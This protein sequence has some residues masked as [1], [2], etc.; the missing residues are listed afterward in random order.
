MGNKQS[1][2]ETSKKGLS[3]VSGNDQ[4]ATHRLQNPSNVTAQVVM[5]LLSDTNRG[6][7]VTAMSITPRQDDDPIELAIPMSPVLR[8]K[9]SSRKSRI[10]EYRSA[11]R[12]NS[13]RQKDY[14]S[15]LE[16]A[17]KSVRKQENE[18][19]SIEEET[20]REDD[21]VQ[22]QK[23]HEAVANANKPSNFQTFYGS[24]MCGFHYLD[25]GL[26]RPFRFTLENV[27]SSALTQ[28]LQVHF[29]PANVYF[30][31]IFN[32]KYDGRLEEGGTLICTVY[33]LPGKL[34]L[35]QRKIRLI[36]L[37]T[38]L[39]KLVKADPVIKEIDFSQNDFKTKTAVRLEE[40]SSASFFTQFT[41][42]ILREIGSNSVLISKVDTDAS[43]HLPDHCTLVCPD[44]TS[45]QMR[46]IDHLNLSFEE[47]WIIKMAS[48]INA[49][50][51]FRLKTST[52]SSLIIKALPLKSLKE[53]WNPLFY[54][55]QEFKIYSNNL[56]HQQHYTNILPFKDFFLTP[57][58]TDK[59]SSL[60]FVYEDFD[61]TLRDILLDKKHRGDQFSVE[62]IIKIFTDIIR[63]LC[64]LHKF[65]IA[66]RNLKPEN[67]VYS[68][69]KRSFMISN[70]SLALVFNKEEAQC[71]C[72]D[73][74]GTPFYMA[75]EIFSDLTIEGSRI[76]FVYDPFKADVYSVG[77]MIVECLWLNMVLVDSSIPPL[78][79]TFAQGEL[80]N[81]ESFLEMC[82]LKH[83][84]QNL[85]LSIIR[86]KSQ[87]LRTLQ[88]YELVKP[89]L[90]NL[91]FE[92]SNAR[93]D[94]FQAKTAMLKVHSSLLEKYGDV[95]GFPNFYVEK[96]RDRN[97][98]DFTKREVKAKE[99]ML[100]CLKN[101]LFL[102]DLNL[103]QRAEV[104][105]QTIESLWTDEA[106]E[107][108]KS[109]YIQ[110]FISRI[111]NLAKLKNLENTIEIIENQLKH[112]GKRHND[113]NYSKLAVQCLKV[114]SQIMFVRSN[115]QEFF[116]TS[117]ACEDLIW[118]LPTAHDEDNKSIR[119]R[120]K[121]SEILMSFWLFNEKSCL[122]MIDSF[123]SLL[124]SNLKNGKVETD[125]LLG[126]MVV[127]ANLQQGEIE[128]RIRTV[129][130]I[131]EKITASSKEN[132]EN[133]YQLYLFAI[134]YL[135][136][137]G[138]N[139]EAIEYSKKMLKLIA[140]NFEGRKA[141][142]LMHQIGV[143]LS[144]QNA[145]TDDLSHD[146]ILA[147]CKE[148]Y[149]VEAEGQSIHT[150][151]S[152]AFFLKYLLSRY[153]SNKELKKLLMNEIKR[154]EQSEEISKIGS[155]RARLLLVQ[156][157]MIDLEYEEAFDSYHSMSDCVN[158][159]EKHSTDYE[160]VY[161]IL[162]LE[163]QIMFEKGMYLDSSKV[164]Q[165]L[166]SKIK[167]NFVPPQCSVAVAARLDIL[168]SHKLLKCY[169]KMENYTASLPLARQLL[170][171]EKPATS[172]TSNTTGILDS[173]KNIINVWTIMSCLKAILNV[174]AKI[175]RDV[176][177]TFYVNRIIQEASIC[178]DP[179]TKLELLY[180]LARHVYLKLARIEKAIMYLDDTNKS[181][182]MQ[183]ADQTGKAAL[184]SLTFRRKQLQLYTKL[185]D[186]TSAHQS[187]LTQKDMKEKRVNVDLITNMLNNC[188]SINS[189]LAKGSNQYNK[190]SIIKAFTV[191]AKAYLKLG[192]TNEALLNLSKA[193]V[194]INSYDIKGP[195]LLKSKITLMFAKVYNLKGKIKEASENGRRALLEF[196]E[197]YGEHSP[198]TE[199]IYTLM[200]RLATSD[201]DK[202][203][204]EE[205]L[206]C[207]IEVPAL[208]DL[209][210]ADI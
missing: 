142:Q 146:R 109:E 30:D 48:D 163:G 133:L 154:V 144:T 25:G 209:D 159:I 176:N 134:Y 55:L 199:A 74:V 104:L 43:A 187:M 116:E 119:L 71:S 110:F 170:S 26:T 78:T 100:L 208:A 50:D 87:G 106:I 57:H 77:V 8:P 197:Y 91:I 200:Q 169:L 92:D 38:E 59:F 210:D 152:I 117:K 151:M 1:P 62:E 206:D 179:F 7:K 207:E 35:K 178:S 21:Y 198:N 22:D 41:I 12:G 135:S 124:K 60:C 162:Q 150:M 190:I 75:I 120:L 153:N 63:G 82:E 6:P 56:Y 191:V 88:S 111:T 182:L 51:Y 158:L 10:N 79:K 168:N 131:E 157:H 98:Y 155:S 54:L 99:D 167:R 126:T 80:D 64:T 81:L 205:T 132:L 19:G 53:S 61:C 181:K 58:P 84:Q 127:L 89:M 18:N 83:K 203:H 40:I 3:M 194:S 188:K 11:M 65:G 66:H 129:K 113:E 185:W 115:V 15:S 67:I 108:H 148:Y 42:E 137:L 52:G 46:L 95:N 39:L 112:Q 202:Q 175:V 140:G 96:I 173:S 37:Q 189:K 125:I 165:E 47:A 9:S 103:R 16:H 69:D 76:K 130:E 171:K 174:D 17:R 23:R 186:M 32:Y 4:E 183:A 24:N 29:S 177:V 149:L 196:Q 45:F 105:D 102:K 138:S 139:I 31:T 121:F 33:S 141:F 118:L 14:Q 160:S 143:V 166:S 195:L 114:K 107:E 201:H 34:K 136:R 172:P 164:Y 5:K 20:E 28:S 101:S 123:I 36:A 122:R 145:G 192:L 128:S 85:F 193:M 86:K 73:L 72:M 68:R 94:A 147:I 90:E 93:Y 27:K 156:T 180:F 204:Y 161:A 184:L 70:M 44:V 97:M 49:F 2:P 13:E